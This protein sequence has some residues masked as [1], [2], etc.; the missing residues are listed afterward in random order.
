MDEYNIH[1]D[2]LKQLN[3]FSKELY[4]KSNFKSLIRIDK[5]LL[6]ITNRIQT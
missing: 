1:I 6:K 3:I 2:N 4:N 5:A